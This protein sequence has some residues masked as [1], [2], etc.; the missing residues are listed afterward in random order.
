MARPVLEHN[1]GGPFTPAQK[2]AELRRELAMRERVYPVQVAA[3]RM[4]L[5]TA[6]TQIALL[7]SILSDYVHIYGNCD[8]EPELFR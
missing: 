3:G 4:K 6:R 8:R 5:S 7:A 2:I 1:N